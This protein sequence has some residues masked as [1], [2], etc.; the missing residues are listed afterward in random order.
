MVPAFLLLVFASSIWL[1]N[2]AMASPNNA[3]RLNETQAVG[4]QAEGTQQSEI[5]DV[6]R[7]NFRRPPAGW[8]KNDFD[9]ADWQQAFGGFGTHDTPGSRIGTVWGTNSIWLRKRFTIGKRPEVP[10]LLIHHD[11]DADVFLNGTLIAKFEGFVSDYKVVPLEENAARSIRDGENLLAI[12]CRQTNGGQFIDAH[13][14]DANAVPK[15]PKPQRSKKP[16]QS[17]LITQWGETLDPASVW[18]E[19]PR[20]QMRRKKWTNLNGHWDYCVTAIE[21]KAPPEKW[22]GQIL[23][24]FSLESKLGGVEQLLDS[25]EALWYH[26]YFELKELPKGDLLLHFEAVDYACEVFVNGVSVGKHQGGNTPF[27]LPIHQSVRAGENDLV[28][29]VVDETEGWQLRG[30]QTLNARGIWYTQVSGIWQTVWLEPVPKQAIRKLKIATDANS[31]MIEVSVHGSAPIHEP[32]HAHLKVRDGDRVIAEVS[33]SASQLRVNIKDAKL[34]SPD[35][36]FLYDLEVTLV[37]AE[38]NELDRVESYTGIRTV[39]KQKDENGNWIFTLNGQPIFH[40]GPLDQGWWPDGLLTPPSDEAMRFD[41]DW[42]K[43]AGFNMIRKHIKVEPRRFYAYCDQI[44]ML[45][46]Q[47]HVSGGQNPPWTRLQPEPTDAQWPKEHHRQFMLELDRM[48]DSLENHPSIVV[49]VPFNEA[50]GQHQTVEVGNWMSKRDPSRLVNVASGGNFW[51]AGD[52]VDEHRYPDPGFPFEHDVNGRFNDYIKVIGEFGGHGYPVQGHLWDVNRRNWGYGGLPQTETEYKQRYV[53]SLDILN[54]LRGRGIAA[55]VYTQTT[56]VE[57]EINGL[58]TYDRKVIKIPATELSKL[59]Q[60]LFNEVPA[61]LQRAQSR[62]P[63]PPM[64]R[65]SIEQGLKTHDRALHIKAGW[66]RDPY[67]VLGPDDAYYLTGTQPNVG[68]SRE[69]TDPY[70]LGL[71]E[72][73]IVGEQVRIWR[74]RDLIEWESLGQ[75]FSV[76]DSRAFKNRKDKSRAN[77]L[78]WAP[79]LHWLGEKWALVHCP[80]PNSSLALTEGLEINGP[81]TQP[82][83]PASNRKHDPSLFQDDDGTWFM[84]WQNTLL[85][86]LSSDFARFTRDPV[87][88]DPSGERLGPEGKPISRIGHEGATMRKIGGKYIHFGTAWSTDQG[89]KGSYNLY[90]CTADRITGPY[91]ERRFVGRFLGHGTPFQDREGKWW[92][93]AFFNANVPPLSREGIQQRDLGDDAQ[94]INEQGVTLVPLEVKIQDDGDVLIRAKDPDYA[95]PGPDESQAF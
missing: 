30:K 14:I 65:E 66:I 8:Q 83:F 29:R 31:G 27:S 53:K 77:R 18:S 74:S 42:L 24:P 37:D 4:K 48:V 78:I 69:A 19:Y 47:D 60:V 41:V 16:F 2:H 50:W 52:I 87:R 86:P 59:H 5:V 81:W 55:G 11:E 45:V 3:V 54:Q 80:G 13:L 73:S 91:G 38:G 94:T 12:H 62:Q 39:G 1:S 75:P 76:D 79:E 72:R 63:A 51:P 93:T 84:L 67:I 28:V 64:N 21:Q 49:W 15:L 95:S 46:W 58:M 9:D 61:D 57:G 6:W 17:E 26:R 40:W 35:S 23:V 34:W 10:A 22:T 25:T 33:G 92:C 70:N 88:I 44:G 90:Y 56:D 68:D 20:P 85:A 43:K 7:I 36:P 82:L 71:G 32:H 89:R